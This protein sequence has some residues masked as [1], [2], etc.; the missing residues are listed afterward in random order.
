MTRKQI[1][2]LFARRASA[3]NHRD[4]AAASRLYTDDAVV[5]SPAAGGTVRG[6]KAVEDVTRALF[7]GFPDITFTSLTLVIDG[8]RAVSIGAIQGTDTGGF[9][10]LPAT[11]KPFRLPIVFVCT[12]RDGLIAHEQRIYDFT[13]M[14]IQIGVLKAQPARTV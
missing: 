13:G 5:D 12:L 11:N 8:D 9:M 3:I 1:E 2:N 10:G 4:V 14:L 6:R 7:S